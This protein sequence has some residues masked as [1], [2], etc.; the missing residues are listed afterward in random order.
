[1][2]QRILMIATIMIFASA[3]ALAF[4]RINATQIAGRADVALAVTGD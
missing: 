1:M 2:F 3:H 4:Y